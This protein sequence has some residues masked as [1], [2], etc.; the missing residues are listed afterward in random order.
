[1]LKKGYNS[2]PTCIAGNHLKQ[3]KIN[4]KEYISYFIKG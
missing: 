3:D 4:N 1:M 2:V